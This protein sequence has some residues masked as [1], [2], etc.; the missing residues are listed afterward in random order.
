MITHLITIGD[1]LLIGQTVNTNAAWIGQQL[2]LLGIK[3]NYSITI[4]DTKEDILEALAYANNKA[5]LVLITGGLGPTKDDITKQTL[6]EFF[7][8]SLVLNVEIAAKIEGYFNAIG[9]PFLEVNRQQAMLPKDCEILQNEVGTASGMWFTKEKTS[10]ISMP[11]VP[12]EMKHIMETGVLPKVKDIFQTK[13]LFHYTVMTQGI[14]ESFLA[15]RIKDWEDDLRANDMD[16]AYLPSP[17]LVRLR[18]SSSKGNKK[19][20]TKKAQ[21]LF[22]LVPSYAYGVEQQTLAEVVGDLLKKKNKTISFAE[23]CTGG[24]LSHLITATPGSSAYY[25]GSIIC[26]SYDIK[27]KELNIPNDILIKKGAVSE[28]VVDILSKE[29]LKKYNTDYSIAISGIAGPDG[30][31]DEKPVGTVWIAVRNSNKV[32]TKRFTFGN[33][34]ERNIQKSALTALNMVRLLILETEYESLPTTV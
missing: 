29:I 2:A 20:V 32:V 22:E 7:D 3:V 15:E 25:E 12:Y 19:A 4:S 27:E 30:G 9:K 5:D 6:C 11:G 16:L 33:N 26:Y 28:Q 31:T 23:S 34:R 24:Y 14:G 10:F 21:Q 17:G 1:E 13:D 8:T 18:I